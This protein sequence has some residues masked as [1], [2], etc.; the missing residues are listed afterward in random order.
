MKDWP[1]KSD[2]VFHRGVVN[3]IPDGLHCIPEFASLNSPWVDTTAT[4]VGKRRNIDAAP[5]TVVVTPRRKVFISEFMPISRMISK[6]YTFIFLL[7]FHPL[8]WGSCAL[9]SLCIDLQESKPNSSCQCKRHIPGK[10]EAVYIPAGGPE[11]H[12]KPHSIRSPHCST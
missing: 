3:F 6:F 9:R 12:R 1:L 5:N 7:C 10:V 4:P 2:V 8:R 11:S